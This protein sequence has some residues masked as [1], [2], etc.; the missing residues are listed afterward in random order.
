MID[1]VRLRILRSRGLVCL[2]SG[3]GPYLSDMYSFIYLTLFSVC[4]GLDISALYCNDNHDYKSKL[5][6][7]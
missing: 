1:L 5:K 3:F 2:A 4:K 6:V 7:A